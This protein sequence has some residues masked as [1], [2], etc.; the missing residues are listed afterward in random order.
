M[1]QGTAFNKY[2]MVKREEIQFMTNRS[3]KFKKKE[4]D[5][6]SHL[7]SMPVFVK[8]SIPFFCDFEISNLSINKG[9]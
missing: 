6:K 3:K 1:A 9:S 7:L 2:V 8:N 5:P 4:N